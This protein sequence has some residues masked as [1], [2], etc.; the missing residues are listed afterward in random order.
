MER[1][2]DAELTSLRDRLGEMARHAE[3]M[4]G[5]SM[6][7]LVRRDLKIGHAVLEHEERANRM[8]TEIDEHAIRLMATQQPVARDLR[9]LLMTT[10]MSTELERIADQ[11][12]NIVE[13]TRLL[14][15]E[16]PLK[17]LVDLP[18]MAEIA[19]GMMRAA[20]QAFFELD[21]Q[22][23][24]DVMAKDDEV[25][26]LKDQIFRELLT[27][28]MEDPRSI[29]RALALILI[30]RNLER[31]GDHATNMAEDVVYLAQGR[32]VRHHIA[33]GTGPAETR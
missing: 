10:R 27:Y 4:V 23:A 11:A 20:I 19:C 8:Q 25:D 6:A 17:P 12:V 24:N 29:R 13:N 9:L 14:V 33:E 30:S 28:M 26:A 32:D 31:I 21:V 5:D 18:K 7:S 15:Q 16:P 3:Q 2:L 1:H 22:R